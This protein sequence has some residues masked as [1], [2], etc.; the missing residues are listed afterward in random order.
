MVDDGPPIDA[1]EEAGRMYDQS[2][3][4]QTE[5]MR[6]LAVMAAELVK[7]DDLIR[8]TEHLLEQLKAKRHQLVT[9]SLPDLFDRCMTDKIGLP[10][11]SCDVVVEA[12]Y[13]AAIKA[14]WPDEQRDAGF[15]ELERVEA[16]DLVRCVLSVT[17]GK[18][19]LEFAREVAEYLRAWNKFEN[20]P[21]TIRREV[22]WNTLTAFVKTE[23]EAGNKH[24][25]DLEKLGA[26]AGREARIIRRARR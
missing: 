17:F 14:D 5:V 9:K 15:D 13:H 24:R 4:P 16:G 21:V 19:E 7:N 12:R 6:E 25:L 10:E 20:R 18:S 8:K 11:E 26:R 2:Q 3:I 22:P 23:M 1:I